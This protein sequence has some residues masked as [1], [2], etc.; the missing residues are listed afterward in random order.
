MAARDD[1]R[2]LSM[3]HYVLAGLSVLF[4][5]FPLL[6]VGMGALFM[7][8]AAWKNE[9]HPP[10]AFLGW[11]FIALGSFFFLMLV[12]WVVMLILAGRSLARQQRWLYCMIVA[13]L[14]C[15][16]FPFGTA[17]GVFTLVTLSR[18]EVKALFV[19]PPRVG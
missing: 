8:S 11:F 17:L 15:A 14:S 1:V 4:A 12:G 6:Y 3:F 18:P 16:S 5:F 2:L 19:A 10:P 9:P 7:S 13:G